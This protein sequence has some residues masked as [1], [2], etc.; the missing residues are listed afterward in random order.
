MTSSRSIFDLATQE[1]RFK[2]IEAE[3]ARNGFWDTPDAT[4][5]ILKERSLLGLRSDAFHGLE[6]DLEEAGILLELA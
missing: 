5:A 4:T 3:I 2:E 6:K 1:K